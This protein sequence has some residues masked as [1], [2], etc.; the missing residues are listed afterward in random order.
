MKT[1]LLNYCSKRIYAIVVSRVHL[2][3]PEEIL[4]AIRE[5]HGVSSKGQKLNS[6]ITQFHREMKNQAFSY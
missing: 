1:R 6:N 3:T 4:V 5:R 2:P